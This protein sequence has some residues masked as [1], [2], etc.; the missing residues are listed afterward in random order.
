MCNPSR[1]YEELKGR[2]QTFDG[3]LRIPNI[4]NERGR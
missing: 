2:K 4:I 1:I 3:E